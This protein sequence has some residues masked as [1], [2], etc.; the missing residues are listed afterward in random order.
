MSSPKSLSSGSLTTN[1]TVATGSG[2]VTYVEAVGGTAILY[3]GSTLGDVLAT[4]TSSGYREFTVPVTFGSSGLYITISAG[5]ATV[6][7]G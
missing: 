3:N 1:G 7:T 5:S 2:V 4:V 6:H